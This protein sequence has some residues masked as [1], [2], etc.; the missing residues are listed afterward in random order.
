MTLT[1]F[2]AEVN[3]LGREKAQRY[4]N[5]KPKPLFPWVH[6]DY[7]DQMLDFYHKQNITPQEAI[8]EIEDEHRA[9]AEWEAR[10][11]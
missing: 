2:A 11:S 3:R 9:E 8:K 5:R 7:C 6:V 4:N 10:V 1:E